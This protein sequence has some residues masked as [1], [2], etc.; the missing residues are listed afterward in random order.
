MYFSAIER[1]RMHPASQPRARTNFARGYL[2]TLTKDTWTRKAG[3]IVRETETNHMDAKSDF[4][5]EIVPGVHELLSK[6]FLLGRAQCFRIL[7]IM[8]LATST[9]VQLMLRL[10]SA[11]VRGRCSNIL[12]R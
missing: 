11:H 5:H 10:H 1:A 6:P 3:I 8:R 12:Y 9:T 7:A 4:M 2:M